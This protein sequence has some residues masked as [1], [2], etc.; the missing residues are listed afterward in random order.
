MPIFVV[1][2]HSELYAITASICCPV[3]RITTHR[4][5]PL[6]TTLNPKLHLNTTEHSNAFIMRTVTASLRNR[7]QSFMN[8]DEYTKITNP[9]TTYFTTNLL[10]RLL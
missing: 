5:L 2:S 4:Q 7:M 6:Q 9:Q 8:S 3:C 1:T 10:A